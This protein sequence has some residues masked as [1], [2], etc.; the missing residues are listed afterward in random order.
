MKV[1][2]QRTCYEFPLAVSDSKF[3]SS[4][5]SIQALPTAKTEHL[6]S[7]TFHV[8][9]KKLQNG[10]QG[11][12]LL[13]HCTHISW[14]QRMTNVFLINSG[15]LIPLRPL[16]VVS[17]EVIYC[18]FT[19]GVIRLA[20]CAERGFAAVLVNKLVSGESLQETE[21]LPIV[22]HPVDVLSFFVKFFC[23]VQF[24]R[25]TFNALEEE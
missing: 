2:I 7:C 18:C 12:T 17:K 4:P 16:E 8:S 22:D 15:Q 14:W 19:V 25:I 1:H 21:P 11:P 3:H 23:S 10:L 9:A 13:P 6:D 5:L 20:N 24:T